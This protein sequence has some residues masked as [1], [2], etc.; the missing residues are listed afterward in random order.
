M[1]KNGDLN[2]ERIRAI[3]LDRAFEKGKAEGQKE[4]KKLVCAVSAS[5]GGIF[6]SLLAYIG[7]Y[8]FN[9]FPAVRAAIEVFLRVS[10]GQ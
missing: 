6:I 4:T 10:G 5:V 7:K 8:L 2:E 3:E 1:V 9:E